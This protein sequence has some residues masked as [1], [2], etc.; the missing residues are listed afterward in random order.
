[1]SP[2]T[3]FHF[4]L[5]LVIY[6]MWIWEMVPSTGKPPD[7]KGQNCRLRDKVPGYTRLQLAEVKYSTLCGT[8]LVIQVSQV[9]EFNIRF[10]TYMTLRCM[11]NAQLQKIGGKSRLA[12][13]GTGFYSFMIQCRLRLTFP[14]WY[15]MQRVHLGHIIKT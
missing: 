12:A 5:V 6:F 9:A 10:N 1:M 4:S 14:S 2:S 11:E 13:F 3:G 7:L 8:K 15:Y